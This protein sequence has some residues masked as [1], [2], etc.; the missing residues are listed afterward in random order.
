[1]G[2]GGIDDL[3]VRVQDERERDGRPLT[4]KIRPRVLVVDDEEPMRVAIRRIL[5]EECEVTVADCGV[6]ALAELDARTYDAVVSDV[7][8]P[9]GGGL[10]LLRSIRRIDL[11]IPVILVSGAPDVKT[12]A[13][14]VEYGAFRY[15]MKPVENAL[16]IDVVRRAVRGHR[17]ARLRREALAAAA[18]AQAGAGDRAGLEVRFEQAVAAMWLAFQPIIRANGAPFG[19]EALV[20]SDEETMADPN[21]LLDA[22]TRLGRLWQVG[23][24]VRSLAAAAVA[25]RS[26]VGCVFVN[27]H[28]EDLGD[29]DLVAAAA[30]L[31]VIA[32]RVVLEITERASLTTSPALHA[33]LARLRELGFRVAV[34]DIGAGYSGLASFTELTPEIVKIDMSL[35]RGIADNPRKQRTVEALCNLCHEV[36]CLVVAEG[37]ETEAERA[38]VVELGCDL[39]QG[40]LLSEPKRGLAR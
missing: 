6:R 34:D 10:D 5:R 4:G 16:M 20:R 38:C 23:R 13:E 29:D 14:A 2:G 30:P 40:F 7:H 32:P 36:D 1:M 12:A 8:M 21:S 28:P 18:G 22:A 19:V 25:S 35:V 9:D 33:R 27:L 15:L 3:R 26:D 24:G 17:F 11:D 31:S 39:L 37:I